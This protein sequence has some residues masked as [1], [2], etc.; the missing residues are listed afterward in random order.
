MKGLLAVLFA[1]LALTTFAILTPD[2]AEG[3]IFSR[4]R[5]ASGCA[6]GSCST[7]TYAPAYV[8]PPARPVVSSAAIINEPF[9]PS[10]R[11]NA[12]DNDPLGVNHQA[13]TEYEVSYRTAA[14]GPVRAVL[15]APARVATAPVRFI[16]NRQPLRRIASRQP[17][18]RI[19]GNC[20]TSRGG[21]FGRRI[22]GR[23]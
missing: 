20:S 2:A 15:A 13:M 8:Q 10:P 19:G 1:V 21:L 17:L 7:A 22:F 9:G 14:Q 11:N 23:R 5:S 16:V 6:D 18:R 12:P 3:G 4:W